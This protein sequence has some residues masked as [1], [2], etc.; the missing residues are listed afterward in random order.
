MNLNYLGGIIDAEGCFRVKKVKSKY[1]SSYTPYFKIE[2]N[3]LVI[4]DLFTKIFGGNYI[5]TKRGTFS[6]ERS[7]SLCITF[8]EQM[9]EFFYLK[10]EEANLLSELNT[11]LKTPNSK[12][13]RSQEK[14]NLLEELYLKSRESKKTE[15]PIEISDERFDAY[16]AGLLDG[17]GCISIVKGKVYKGKQYYEVRISLE[18]TAETL[19]R[20]I[21]AKL[22]R[23]VWIREYTNPNHRTNYSISLPKSHCILVRIEPF[24]IL[25]KEKLQTILYKNI[26]NQDLTTVGKM[27]R[28]KEDLK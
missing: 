24:L 13:K 17:D 21:A 5:E 28:A 4:I 22:N 6:Y 10:R 9:K 27:F 15:K 16:L 26:Q 11:I 2:M 3:N 12:R 7:A 23:P 1:G 25:K 20:T 19:I 14:N 8:I 18:M